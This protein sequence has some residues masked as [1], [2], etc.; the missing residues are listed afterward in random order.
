MIEIKMLKQSSSHR[1]QVQLIQFILTQYNKNML[2]IVTT[3]D[4]SN[5][6]L[7]LLSS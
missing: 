5:N 3:M 1:N 7:S 6:S 2:K 4:S